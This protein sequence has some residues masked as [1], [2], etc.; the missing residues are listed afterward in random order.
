MRHD[1]RT[2]AQ[3]ITA[4]LSDLQHN[5]AEARHA[6]H[7]VRSAMEFEACSGK[8]GMPPLRAADLLT[9]ALNALKRIAN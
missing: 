5:L 7:S 9:D 8:E 2:N 3:A 4:V 6:I 1:D